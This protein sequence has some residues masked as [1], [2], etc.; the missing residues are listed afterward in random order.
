FNNVEFRQGEIENIPVGGNQ[1]DVVISNCVLNLVSDKEKSFGEIFRVLKP[2]AHFSISDVVLVGDLPEEI[3]K[4]AE[5]YA[6]C[7]GGAI[8]KDT[9]LDIIY[10]AG[11]KN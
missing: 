5:M 3:V 4:S 7:V 1:A 10:K 2:G 11:F 9:Y 8:Q 6:G